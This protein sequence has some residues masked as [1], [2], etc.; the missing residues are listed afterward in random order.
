M[1]CRKRHRCA[2]NLVKAGNLMGVRQH[3]KDSR[4]VNAYSGEEVSNE[5]P[6]IPLAKPSSNSSILPSIIDSWDM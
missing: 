5:P 1:S 4:V 2:K 3:H 6:W